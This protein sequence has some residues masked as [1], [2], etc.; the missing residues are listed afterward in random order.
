MNEDLLVQGLL[1]LLG[2]SRTKLSEADLEQVEIALAAIED[3]PLQEGE[4]RFIY[5]RSREICGV[6]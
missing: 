1:R 6:V 3:I 4:L 5:Q 2:P